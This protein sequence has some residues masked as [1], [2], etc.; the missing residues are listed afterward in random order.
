MKHTM[1]RPFRGVGQASRLRRERISASSAWPP[2]R[3]GGAPALLP[4][5]FTL[6]ELLVVIAI[7]A[8]LAGLL[9][10]AL[11]RAKSKALDARSMNNLRQLG[12]A[13]TVYADEN[14]GLLP[15]A[16]RLPSMPIAMP[17]L[18]EP[19]ISMVLSNAV[20]GVMR[21][22]ECPLDR[23]AGRQPYFQTEGSS[24]EWNAAF[25]HQPIS[26]PR[27]FIFNLPPQQVALMYDYE[28]FHLGGTNGLKVVLYAD[29]H[30]QKL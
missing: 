29:G 15:A 10:P 25:N 26:A 12:I 14:Q 27:L 6:I 3:A 16:E 20:S 24:Y 2:T 21:I 8:I 1:R 17:A 9:L 23:P 7:I 13:L 4:R 11:S 22:F 30:V 28:N 19:R 18:P 5:A